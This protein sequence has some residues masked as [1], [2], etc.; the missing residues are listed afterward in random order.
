M[1]L[2]R[3]PKPG[4]QERTDANNIGRRLISRGPIRGGLDL[5]RLR[6]AGTTARWMLAQ[7]GEFSSSPPKNSTET[8]DERGARLQLVGCTTCSLPVRRAEGPCSTT[9]PNLIN[10]EDRCF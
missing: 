3:I 1:F 4:D 9:D 6:Q 10:L 8:V 7:K 5:E 2:F